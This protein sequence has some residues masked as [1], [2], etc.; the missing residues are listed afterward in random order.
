MLRTAAS[1]EA[2][3]RGYLCGLLQ[4]LKVSLEDSSLGQ[5]L[6]NAALNFRRALGCSSGSCAE[7]L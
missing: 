2:S 7:A 3:G 4:W 1:K 5:S 6:C